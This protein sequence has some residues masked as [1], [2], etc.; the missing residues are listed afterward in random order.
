MT[1]VRALRMINRR[2]IL[3]YWSYSISQGDSSRVLANNFLF[4]QKFPLG[5]SAAF[6]AYVC[7]RHFSINIKSRIFMA[8]CTKNRLY[9][10]VSPKK[11][12]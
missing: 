1:N 11:E 7:E 4:H 3:I 2:V 10:A 5:E 6:C 8:L 12:W 9:T